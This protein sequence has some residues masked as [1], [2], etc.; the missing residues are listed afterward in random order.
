MPSRSVEGGGDP[1]GVDKWVFDVS[2]AIVDL[3][4][5]ALDGD[6]ANSSGV[7]P[8]GDGASGHDFKFQVNVVRGD[9]NRSSVVLGDDVILVR[10][11]QFRGTT[12][13]QYSSFLDLN[14]SGTILR[15]DVILARNAQFT[16]VPAGSHDLTGP[17]FA[18]ALANDTGQSASDRI[19]S[20]AAVSATVND[21]SGITLFTAS[22]N[23][24]AFVDI[25]GFRN[26][27][28]TFSLNAAALALVNGGQPLPD[29]A[30]TLRIEAEDGFG[31]ATTFNLSFTLDTARPLG[32]IPIVG[33]NP[34]TFSAFDVI[35]T[36]AMG[37]AAFQ[38]GSYTLEALTGP[39]A[40]QMIAVTGVQEST[41]STALLQLATTLADGD[42]RL[43][44]SPALT[45]VT[46]NALDGPTTFNFTV[47][48]PVGITSISPA[49]GEELVS[50]TRETI[51]RFEDA[52]DPATI[53]PASFQVMANGQPV[54]GSI[55][56]SSTERFVTF[57]HDAPLP[58]STAVRVVLNGHLIM[59]RDGM[60]PDADGDNQPGGVSTANFK[61]LP[62]T[63]IA[64]TNVFGFVRDSYSGLPLVGATIRIDAFPEANVVTDAD[65]RFDL[66][67]MPAPDFFVHIDG[68]TATHVNDGG[69]LVAIS[70]GT[71]YPNVGKPFHSVPG[72]TVQLNMQGTP[73]DVFLPPMSM[74]DVSTLSMTISTSVG[75]GAAGLA[76]L[77]AMFPEVDPQV[78]ARTGVTFAPTMWRSAWALCP[79][80]QRKA[81]LR[82]N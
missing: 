32:S 6:W 52:V 46:G 21:A 67:N 75:F 81:D 68:S 76:E 37:A 69:N 74:G 66:T 29:G 40:G 64:G 14:G 55:V 82:S 79:D 15:D 4:G 25:A 33:T 41:S 65:G 45:D 60:V 70:A 38:T 71:M 39:N 7:F 23:G 36:E 19:T 53:T 35:F 22:L 3:A 58:A 63:R 72:Q 49:S 34:V 13:P 78:W 59:G 5:N 8:S 77:A 2:D 54:P 28:G 24:G 30:H 56:V 26:V 27:D 31:N 42:Y 57:F 80:L 47:S 18:A 1:L 9:A 44:A 11:A 43:T 61:T 62:L 48:D 20:N 10:N 12:H 51:V 50:V 16:T 17:S 73:F